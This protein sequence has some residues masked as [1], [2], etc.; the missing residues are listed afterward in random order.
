MGKARTLPVEAI[1]SELTGAL[2]RH[3]AVVLTAP[4]GA[5][6]TTLVPLALVRAGLARGGQVVVLQPRRLAARAVARR[7]AGLLGEPVGR[8]VGF[9][10][11]FER[12]DS[13][14]TRVLVVTEGVL[15]RRLLSDPLL[16]GVGCVVLDEFHERSVHLDLALAFLRE[17]IQVRDDLKLVVMS[18]TLDPGPIARFLGSCP[19]VHCPAREHPLSVEYIER[20]DR[21]SLPERVR[22]GL[23]R[24]LQ[25]DDEEKGDILAFLPGASEIRRTERLL[26]ERPLP[27]GLAVVPLY[28]ALEAAEQDRALR[29]G[30][31]RRVVLATNIAETSLT[32]PGVTAVVDTGLVKRLQSDP[33]TGMDRLQTGRVSRASADQR[34]G[35]A[36]RT[37]P[38]RVLRLW[39][40]SEHAGLAPADRPQIQR[41]DLAP[42][43]LSVLSFQPG[44]LCDF[45]FFERPSEPALDAAVALLRMLGAI[46]P[47]EMRLTGLGAEM[48]GLPVH[49]R[50]GVVLHRAASAGLL[51]DGA[52][53]AA[54]LSERDIFVFDKRLGPAL[55]TGDSDLLHRRDAYLDL[56]GS[57]FSASRARE[58]GVDMGAARDV[59]NASRQLASGVRTRGERDEPATERE[60]R[61]FVLAG[62]PDRV[63]RRRKPGK[64]EALMVG[65]RG[66][67][68]A[69]ESGVRDA[70]LFVA[71][72]ADAGPRGSHA[73]GLVR[74]AS[75]VDVEDLREVFPGRLRERVEA[76]FDP[77]SRAVK[78]SGK[79]LFEELEIAEQTG[80]SV[81]ADEAAALLAEAAGS[82]FDEV[83]RPDAFGRQMIARLRFASRH[84]PDADWPDVSEPGLRSMLAELCEGRRS[85]DELLRIDWAARLASRLDWRFTKLLDQ[86]APERIRVPSGNRVRI[87]Y[88]RADAPVL[89][90]KLQEMFG[91]ADTPRIARGRVPLL[92]HLLAPNGRPVQVTADLKS[93]WEQ[94]YPEVRRDLR[95]R[96]PRHP[97]PEDPWTARPTA[98]T[99]RRS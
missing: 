4:P 69:D 45:A 66:M 62:F 74:V 71:L 50:L 34:A 12:K 90:V 32:V 36:G 6:K 8:T 59:T 40:A 57:G 91:L 18:A 94:A 96:Y 88:S 75:A 64:P 28:G 97:W 84:L 33:R 24:L 14:H 30:E 81:P 82:R 16:D 63:C 48:A 13:K 92:L 46:A 47:G 39:T 76:R 10:V 72:V 23:V 26:H 25:K 78:G 67:R 38:G 52:L 56:K 68:L 2:G 55:P 15:T 60:L 73:T 83:F 31:D 80:V 29:P 3:P 77:Q 41:C 42:V 70:D 95:G 79:I 98:R 43:V 87:D 22:A 5:G 17:L 11:R 9:Q 53:L 51:S 65:G 19:Q 58:L 7:M 86:E 35:R 27:G 99:G 93:F 37:A 85:F 61:R 54:L 1:L 49:P 21:R 89:A 44:P 20:P